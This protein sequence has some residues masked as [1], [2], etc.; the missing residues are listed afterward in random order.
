MEQSVHFEILVEDKS[1]E[2][3][4]E[5][6]VPKIIL[7]KNCTY[8]LHSYNGIERRLP[9]NMNSKADPQKR[10]LSA[11]LPKLLRGYGSQ[12]N[13]SQIVIV[14]ID[15]DSR[16]YDSFIGELQGILNQ[17][18]PK[19]QAYFCL[20]IEE[21]EAW[22]LADK[23]AVLKAY[24]EAGKE[25]LKN[26]VPDSICGTWET[27]AIAINGPVKKGKP[28]ANKSEWAKNIS[29]HVDVENHRS[30]SFQRFRDTLRGCCQ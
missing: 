3:M 13:D 10:I 16:D 17:C 7:N 19:P 25:I 1:G 29:P 9:Q 30:P 6:L 22:L 14:V 5:V 24:P 18:D 15:L 4:L 23:N 21:G 28:Q 20:A 12:R 11:L 26:Y 27:L 8:N 2:Y